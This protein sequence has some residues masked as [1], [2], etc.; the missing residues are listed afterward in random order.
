V[1]IVEK[2]EG[3]IRHGAGRHEKKAGQEN[4]NQHD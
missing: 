4:E 2:D 3:L 1:L